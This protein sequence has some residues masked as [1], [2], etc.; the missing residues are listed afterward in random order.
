MQLTSIKLALIAP[1]AAIVPLTLTALALALV[2]IMSLA[3][4]DAR[5]QHALQVLDRL[6]VFAF[7]L[8]GGPPHG[9]GGDVTARALEGPS[10]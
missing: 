8:R 2:S 6:A 3:M 9:E 7:V 4:P 5:R 1:A 10:P